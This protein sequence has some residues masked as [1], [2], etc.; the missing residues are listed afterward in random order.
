MVS[1]P[2]CKINL[3][4]KIL[5]KRP[6]GY[7]DLSTIFYPLPLHDV[8][9]ILHAPENSFTAYG[10][11]I[12]SN[13]NAN[14]TPIPG[15]ANGNLCEQAWLLLKADFPA[16]PNVQLHLYKNIPIGAGLG[17][18]S[19][20]GAFTLL[21]LNKQFHLGLDTPALIDYAAQLGSDCPFFILNIPSL[22]GGRG[23]Q[24]EPIPLDLSAYRFILVN[25][26]IHIST[27]QA[28]GLCTPRETGMPLR[29]IIRQ[30]MATWSGSLVNDFEEPVFRLHPRLREIKETLYAHGAVYA[31]LTGSGSSFYGIFE[32]AGTPASLPLSWNYRTLP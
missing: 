7:H 23:E 8:L 13:G 4:L 9:E 10:I 28:F 29:D 21:A 12:P 31:S 5:R 19:A 25:P 17:G 3:G 26:G 1:F 27:A 22:G 16:L 24:L 14:P 15:A 11:P 30:P 2:N 20:D 18:G 32:R 6:D